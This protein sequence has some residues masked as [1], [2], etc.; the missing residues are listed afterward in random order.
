MIQGRYHECGGRA[1]KRLRRAAKEKCTAN[2]LAAQSHQCS[3]STPLPRQRWLTLEPI[4]LAKAE[5]LNTYK[6]LGTFPVAPQS[7]ECT[8]RLLFCILSL[9]LYYVGTESRVSSGTTGS[10]RGLGKHKP[11][12]HPRYF[13][14]TNWGFPHVLCTALLTQRYLSKAMQF[15]QPPPLQE[16]SCQSSVLLR[17]LVTLH[18][19][20]A[21]CQ[22]QSLAP[23][24]SFLT[25]QWSESCYDLLQHG[26]GSSSGPPSLS[27]QPLALVVRTPAMENLIVATLHLLLCEFIIQK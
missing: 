20:N 23:L 9:S 10:K 6:L 5:L 16:R 14:Q 15:H 4:S 7:Q 8:R 2:W 25:P 19:G 24:M 3:F 18:S 21:T 1:I 26:T 12:L 13:H 27:G 17:L 11:P 22:K